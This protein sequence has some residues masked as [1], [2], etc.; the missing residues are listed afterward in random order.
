MVCG[1]QTHWHMQQRRVDVTCAACGLVLCQAAER[2]D[3]RALRVMHCFAYSCKALQSSISK[4]GVAAVSIGMCRPELSSWPETDAPLLPSLE[5]SVALVAAASA[6]GVCS[7]AVRIAASLQSLAARAVCMSAAMPD[8]GASC[9]C[10]R[11]GGSQR[12]FAC[13]PRKLRTLC[14]LSNG[15]RCMLTCCMCVAAATWLLN[16]YDT[17]PPLSRS[18]KPC[19]CFA[20]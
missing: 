11:V 2:S 17:P 19:S 15:A 8:A 4:R 5:G 18:A 10:A 6:A 9:C 3:G 13:G 14:L 16:V 7:A 12:A 20:S 1:Q